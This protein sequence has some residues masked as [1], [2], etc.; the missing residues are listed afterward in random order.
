MENK[1]NEL[2][3]HFEEQKCNS[4]KNKLSLQSINAQ[5][6]FFQEEEI[7]EEIIEAAIALVLVSEA[8]K[9]D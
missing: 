1:V 3:K 9:E 5:Q 6:N 7:L 2:W 8:E 4:N